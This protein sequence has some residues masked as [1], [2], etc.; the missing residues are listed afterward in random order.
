MEN[1]LL[2][3]LKYDSND[4]YLA[5]GWGD[6][7]FYINTPTWAELTFKNAINAMFLQSSTLMHV[8]RYARKRSDW[9]EVRLNQQELA[10]LNSYVHNTFQLD[11]QGNKIILNGQGYGTYDEFYRAK[12]S[13][14][15]FKTCNSWVNSAFKQNGLRSC[16]WTPFDFGLM[17]AY[18]P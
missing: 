1:S 16:L 12:G 17:H 3:G 9:V 10:Q 15:C 13:Y 4:S 2:T 14:S 7:N 18:A 6:E 5:F 8:T 11:E